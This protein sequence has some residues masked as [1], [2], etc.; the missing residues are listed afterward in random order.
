M[1]RSR[2]RRGETLAETIAAVLII[3]LASVAFLTLAQTA[4]RLNAEARAAEDVFT[5][6]QNGVLTSSET[7][8]AAVTVVI[9]NSSVDYS[10]RAAG[11]SSGGALRAYDP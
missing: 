7:S 9:G 10:V 11:G 4:S 2:S 1:K 8:S 3:T 6:E 5:A